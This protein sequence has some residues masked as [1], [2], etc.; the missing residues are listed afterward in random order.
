MYDDLH[1]WLILGTN[2][3]DVLSA[4]DDR[5]FG[6]STDFVIAVPSDTDGF[7]LYDAYNIFKERGTQLNVTLIGY[8]NDDSRLTITIMQDKFARRANL[9]QLRLKAI[10]F[11]VRIFSMII[12]KFFD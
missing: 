12:P 10:F 7:V 2:L 8:W 5:A 3:S 1:Y 4:I 9:H 6:F 11:K